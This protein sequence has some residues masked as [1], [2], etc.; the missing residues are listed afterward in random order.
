M[1]ATCTARQRGQRVQRR[2]VA[3]QCAWAQDGVVELG[4]LGCPNLPQGQVEDEA[5]GAGAMSLAGTSGVGALFV[6]HRG[7][8]AYVTDLWGP[9]VRAG[10]AAGAGGVCHRQA[11]DRM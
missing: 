10:L 2:G 1:R 11:G 4:L 7:Q 8:G 3:W 6:A 5:G 9:P